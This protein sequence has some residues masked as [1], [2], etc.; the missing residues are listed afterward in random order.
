MTLGGADSTRVAPP[1][2]LP[3]TDRMLTVAQVAAELQLTKRTV[4]RLINA[5]ELEVV[6]IVGSVRVERAELERLIADNRE[7]RPA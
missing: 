7:R 6:R 3:S 1:D 4:W 2:S 5:G